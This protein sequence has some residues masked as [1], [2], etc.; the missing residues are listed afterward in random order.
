MSQAPRTP[1]VVKS[2]GAIFLTKEAALETAHS[3]EATEAEHRAAIETLTRIAR[4]E[5]M[6]AREAA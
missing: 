5:L 1:P 2:P 3:L 6:P 4:A